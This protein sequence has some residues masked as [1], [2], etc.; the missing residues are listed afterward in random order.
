MCSPFFPSSL[1]LSYPSL[2]PSFLNTNMFL[3]FSFLK[4]V[5]MYIQRGNQETAKGLESYT[6]TI[7]SS[8]IILSPAFWT[9]NELPSTPNK[10]LNELLII[11]GNEKLLTSLERGKVAVNACN[12]K[13][14]CKCL[15]SWIAA[16]WESLEH[17]FSN[18]YTLITILVLFMQYV[19]IMVCS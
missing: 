13:K 12:F 7:L 1:F 3:S 4:V 5:F 8:P 19:I 17:Q 6:N 15:L 11:D 18:Y 2:N 14:L 16:K 9:A 10:K